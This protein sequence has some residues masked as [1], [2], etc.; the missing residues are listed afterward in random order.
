MRI[1]FLE[2]GHLDSHQEYLTENGV[3]IPAMKKGAIYSDQDD[4]G[5]RGM[6]CKS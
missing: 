6:D 5:V 3:N 4:S 2:H 1:K